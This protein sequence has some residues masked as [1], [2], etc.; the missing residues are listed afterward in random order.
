MAQGNKALCTGNAR[1]RSLASTHADVIRVGWCYSWVG[2]GSP[3]ATGCD[4]PKAR[5]LLSPALGVCEDSKEKFF[6]VAL[7]LSELVVPLLVHPM[8]ATKGSGAQEG[9]G[10][11]TRAHREV[12]AAAPLSTLVHVG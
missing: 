2:L 12:A 10:S 5:G 4:G 6:G 9:A 1:G 8:T 3:L 11:L 7:A